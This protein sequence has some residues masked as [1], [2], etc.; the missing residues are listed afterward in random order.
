[1]R[2]EISLL[3]VM[4]VCGCIESMA[5]STAKSNDTTVDALFTEL[6]NPATTSSLPQGETT[7]ST[8]ATTTTSTVR[9]TSTTTSTASTTTTILKDIECKQIAN[10]MTPAD[11]RRGYCSAPGAECRYFPGT[12]VSGQ[13]RCVCMIPSKD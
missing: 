6:L 8:I 1:M 3:L 11:C 10:P 9:T 13:A 12:L 2:F 4:L 5:P 7:T